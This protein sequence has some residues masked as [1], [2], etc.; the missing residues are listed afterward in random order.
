M[1]RDMSEAKVKRPVISEWVKPDIQEH[2]NKYWGGDF[3]RASNHL[4]EI[5]I[6]K[7]KESN[8]VKKEG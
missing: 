6:N 8:R 4:I 3:T 7:I 1:R 2:A 5:G